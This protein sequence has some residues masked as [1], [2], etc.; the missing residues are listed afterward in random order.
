[1]DYKTIKMRSLFSNWFIAWAIISIILVIIFCLFPWL[2]SPDTGSQIIMATFM[3]MPVRDW[4]FRFFVWIIE[5]MAT[6]NATFRV[7]A[8]KLFTIRGLDTDKVTLDGR[9]YMILKAIISFITLIMALF[10]IVFRSA[11]HYAVL[12]FLNTIEFIVR[13]K[14]SPIALLLYL[15]IFG[16]FIIGL[17]RYILSITSKEMYEE[18]EN[19]DD[20][21]DDDFDNEPTVSIRYNWSKALWQSALMLAAYYLKIILTAV[22]LK[23]TLK[24]F[25]AALILWTGFLILAVAVA[26]L[27]RFWVVSKFGD[28]KK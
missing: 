19:D 24:M 2:L 28:K 22:L 18:V 20:D 1:M 23:Y 16:A 25:G 5:Y 9:H 7:Y 15:I 10:W 3:L 13:G 21:D 26:V 11:S 17:W 14:I 4:A 6:I 8:K 27:F 12:T